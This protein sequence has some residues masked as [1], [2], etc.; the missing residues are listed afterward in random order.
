MPVAVS[1]RRYVLEGPADRHQAVARWKAGSRRPNQAAGSD[2]RG[3]KAISAAP[4]SG[5]STPRVAGTTRTSARGPGRANRGQLRVDGVADQRVQ[6]AVRAAE[7]HEPRVED[8]HQPGEP[9][10]EPAPDVRDGRGRG[11]GARLGLAAGRRR[12]RRGPRRPGDPPARAACPR[13]P[14]SPS[15]RREPQRQGAPSGLTVTWPISPAN[16]AD[17]G[18]QAA[19]DDQAAAH[20]DLARDVEHVVDADRRAPP[21]L[22]EDAGVGVV[23]DADRHGDGQRARETAAERDVDPA[24]VRGD[25]TNPSTRRTTPATATPMP[26]IGQSPRDRRSAAR[27]ARSVDHVVD[28]QLAARPLDAGRAPGSRRRGRRSRPRSSRRGSRG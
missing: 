6:P 11:L 24:E 4:T 17:A 16:P 9:D 14:R 21:V 28:R 7:D 12:C 25:D 3:S 1:R 10:A 20:A 27:A 2:N 5:A 8:V 26:T 18:Q 23:D 13:R 15:S 19:V 22:A